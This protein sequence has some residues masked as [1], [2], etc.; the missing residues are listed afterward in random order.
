MGALSEARYFEKSSGG[1]VRHWQISRDGIRCHMSWGL[2]GGRARGSSMTLDDEAHAERHFN[3]KISEKKGQGYV[4]VAP[5]KVVKAA[6]VTADAKLLD[7]MREREE[8]RYEGA[9]DFYWTGYEPVEGHAGVFAKFHDFQAGPGPFYD[10]LVLSEDGRRGLHFV[11]KKPGHD[12][13]SVSAFLDFI[14]PRLELAFDGRSHHKVLLPSAIGQFDHALF[15]APSLCGNRYGGRLGAALPVLDCEICDEDTETLVEARLRG[16]DSM[17]STTWDRAPFP[18]IDLRF[19]LRSENGFEELGGKSSV[20]EK[21][22]KVYPRSMLERGMR[23][24]SEAVPGSRL[25]IRNY[26]REVL[27][28][29]RADLTQ[30]TPAEVDRFLM[31]GPRHRAAGW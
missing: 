7:V 10:Y 5:G 31:G 29:T 16:R 13:T 3:K 30:Q 9:W 27:V 17:P 6:D 2:L 20:S 21:K 11:V 18:V 24:L 12:P 23:L 8:K 19:D 25:E 1:V 4:E 26:R 28:L 22:F 14:R 15:C